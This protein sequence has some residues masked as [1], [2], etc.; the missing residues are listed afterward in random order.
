M[1][2]VKEVSKILMVTPQTVRTYDQ[3]GILTADYV[4]HSG[5]RFYEE[6]KVMKFYEE[7]VRDNGSTED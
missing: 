2:S 4:S 7:G 1:L 5:R 3:K 6:E